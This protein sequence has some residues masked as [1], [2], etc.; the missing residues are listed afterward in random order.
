MPLWKS[1]LCDTIGNDDLMS[2]CAVASLFPTFVKPTEIKLDL[3][4]NFIIY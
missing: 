4:F 2:V 1:V 3:N